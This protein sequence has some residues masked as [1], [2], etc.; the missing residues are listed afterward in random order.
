[1]TKLKLFSRVHIHATKNILI[2][3][4]DRNH[5]KKNDLVYIRNFALS[6]KSQYISKKFSPLFT[7]PFKVFAKLSPVS[8]KLQ[9]T[10]NNKLLKH[11]YHIQNLKP[12]YG[13]FPLV[14]KPKTFVTQNMNSKLMSPLYLRRGLQTTDGYNDDITSVS[15]FNSNLTNNKL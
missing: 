7:G 9:N 12:F 15:I 6:K 5:L 11:T 3:D 10:K 4:A 14:E 13:T 8:Y 1:M 2:N